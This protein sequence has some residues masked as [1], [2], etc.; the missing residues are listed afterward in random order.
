MYWN[1]PILLVVEAR[2]ESD[3]VAGNGIGRG[4]SPPRRRVTASLPRSEISVKPEPR[5]GE[6]SLAFLPAR[7]VAA[8]PSGRP[9]PGPLENV[10]SWSR[11]S[12]SNWT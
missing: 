6:L 7:V 5:N 2:S 10:D 3:S 9:V 11:L 12:T 4:R 1:N 8:E